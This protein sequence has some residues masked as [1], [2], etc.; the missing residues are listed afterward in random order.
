MLKLS[1]TKNDLLI[2]WTNGK[3]VSY[4]YQHPCSEICKDFSLFFV[5]NIFELFSIY[6]YHYCVMWITG[7]LLALDGEVLATDGELL[8]IE[9]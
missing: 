2:I 4:A 6:T 3:K 7:E 5:I 8:A 9:L 1:K